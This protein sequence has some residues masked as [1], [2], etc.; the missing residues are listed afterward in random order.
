MRT[1]AFE[2]DIVREKRT[3]SLNLFHCRAPAST[4]FACSRASTK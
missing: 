2:G 1:C 3:P 4:S